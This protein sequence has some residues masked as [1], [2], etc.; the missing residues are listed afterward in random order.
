MHERLVGGAKR[1]QL[2][3]LREFSLMHPKDVARQEQQ[4]AYYEKLK[5]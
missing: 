5:S 4:N 2:P 3:P 1:A